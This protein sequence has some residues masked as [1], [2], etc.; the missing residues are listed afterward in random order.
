M[1]HESVD[2]C[3]NVIIEDSGP[4]VPD[5]Y[6]GRLGE[7]FFRLPGSPDGGSGLGLA[8]ARRI[9]ARAGAVIDFARSE[10][11][12]LRVTI[13]FPASFRAA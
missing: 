3:V 7:R 8:I 2:G 9:A 5:E 12:G 6:L 1:V 4:G 13:R 11:G 10:I